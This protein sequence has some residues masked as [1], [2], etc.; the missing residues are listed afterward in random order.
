MKTNI[1]DVNKRQVTNMDLMIG[2]R[3][4]SR[5]IQQKVSQ[6]ELGKG[7]KPPVSFQQIQKYEKGVN[8]IGSARLVD[9]AR[10]LEVNTDYFIGDLGGPT[11][12]RSKSD[13]AFAEF[14]AS[15]DGVAIIEAMLAIQK[16]EV[17]RSVI[18]LAR[19]LASVNS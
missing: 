6:A 3:V 11:R 8:R 15:R 19:K 5:R 10:V 16:L 17:R 4:R 1:K 18:D 12:R 9:I 2:Q 13:E 14:M 7:M